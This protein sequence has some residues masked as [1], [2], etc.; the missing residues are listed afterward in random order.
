MSAACTGDIV[1]GGGGGGGN[2]DPVVG[3]S[4]GGETNIIS[5][6]WEESPIR[7]GNNVKM[8][9]F[10]QIKAEVAR[11][12]GVT[13]DWGD[14]AAILGAADYQSSFRDDRTPSAT[15]IITLRKV[16]FDVCDKMMKA[17]ALAP[18]V[19]S[20]LS[21]KDPVSAQDSKVAAQVALI[22][23]HFFLEEPTQAEVDLSTQALA[24]Q[25]T[26]GAT[27]TAAWTGLCTGYL[28]SMRFLTY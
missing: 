24:G 2:D 5:E 28:S 15:K 20:A 16:A 1:G 9:N 11:A 10:R 23:S 14:K 17:E 8:L 26:A 27:P 21:P 22:F 13:Y 3:T 18:K 7:F 19:F 12:T 6:G 25:V 4:A